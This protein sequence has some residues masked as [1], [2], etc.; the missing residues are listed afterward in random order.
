MARKHIACSVFALLILAAAGT[1]HASGTFL[2]KYAHPSAYPGDGHF[3]GPIATPNGCL[4]GGCGHLLLRQIYIGDFN[5][6]HITDVLYRD[7]NW[8]LWPGGSNGVFGPPVITDNQCGDG[9]C[10]QLSDDNILLGDFNGDGITD[11]LNRGDHFR[12]WLGS[13]SGQFSSP[14][15]SMVFCFSASCS[16]LVPKRLFVGD[17]NGDGI[18][19]LLYLGPNLTLWPG[20]R[21][22]NFGGPIET[23]G[24]CG[25]QDCD[26]IAPAQFRIGDFNGDHI[27]DVLLRDTNLKVWLGTRSRQFD[28]PKESV[29]GCFDR[30]CSQLSASKFHVGDF[31][32]DGIEDVLYRDRTFRLRLGRKDGTFGDTIDAPQGC[33]SMSCANLDWRRIYIGDFTGDAISDVLYLGHNLTVWAGT[34]D[35][36]F[37]SAVETTGGCGDVTCDKLDPYTVHIG[38]FNGDHSLDL[39]HRGDRFEVWLSGGS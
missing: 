36:Q 20:Q 12:V 29:G 14:V 17:F 33:G 18:S 7:Q 1:C 19:D 32:G 37:A 25:A 28:G 4:A 34:R 16:L 23:S 6:D 24:G 5:G 10:D 35:G 11:V 8:T 38:D 21:D 30:Q 3:T 31:N 26:Q 13:R 2:W 15:T 27:S 39:L 9:P 22:G